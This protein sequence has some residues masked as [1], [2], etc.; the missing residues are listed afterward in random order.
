MVSRF[1]VYQ[2]TSREMISPCYRSTPFGPARRSWIRTSGA[3]KPP[4]TEIVWQ[5]DGNSGHED[6]TV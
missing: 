1:W 4:V 3:A 6:S 2:S 5:D